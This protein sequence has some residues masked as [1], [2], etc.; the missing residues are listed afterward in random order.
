[1][2]EFPINKEFPP[3]F[4]KYGKKYNGYKNEIQEVIFY[5]F[6]TINYDLELI[7]KGKAYYFQNDITGT[8]Q[9]FGQSESVKFGE[10]YGPCFKDAN[11]LI[12]YFRFDDGKLFIDAIDDIDYAE[13]Y[14]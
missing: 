5:D 9:C 11:D 14:C 3:D 12:K 4:E 13:P 7:Y 8:Y 6:A 1:M 2:T 10:P